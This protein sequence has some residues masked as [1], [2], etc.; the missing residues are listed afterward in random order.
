MAA[1]IMLEKPPPRESSATARV[2]DGCAATSAMTQS[3][4]AMMP[5]YVPEPEQPSTC[6]GMIV[7]A[8]ATPYVVPPMVEAQCVP[9]DGMR[10]G[11]CEERCI[12]QGERACRLASHRGRCTSHLQCRLADSRRPS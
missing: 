6:T 11:A 3:M 9:A 7:A 5:E 4:P 2:P 12:V 8:F 1:F 10:W